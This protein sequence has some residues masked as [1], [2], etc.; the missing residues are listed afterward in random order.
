MSSKPASRKA[1]AS[2]TVMLKDMFQNL[3][4]R[5]GLGDDAIDHGT[6]SVFEAL[7]P[8]FLL[9]ANPL[10][11]IDDRTR[12]LGSSPLLNDDIAAIYMTAT[13]EQAESAAEAATGRITA[14]D[15]SGDVA[16]KSAGP[17]VEIIHNAAPEIAVG[18][19]VTLSVQAADS[20]EIA[21]RSLS[22][23]GKSVSLDSSH[24]AEYAFTASGSYIVVASARNAEGVTGAKTI[25]L[26]V[27]SNAADAPASAPAVQD[28]RAGMARM[29][30]MRNGDIE[31][32]TVGITHNAVGQ[33]VAGQTV[34]FGVVA[35]D[36]TGVT[37]RELIVNG[38]KVTLGADYK[39]AYTFTAPGTYTILAT[40][41]DA[42]KNVGIA[43]LV[44]TVVADSSEMPGVGIGHDAGQN[45]V[46]GQTVNFDLSSD[47]KYPAARYELSV[48]GRAVA[49]DG[50]GRAAY[51]FDRAGV[52]T[53][54]ATVVDTKGNIGRQTMVLSVAAVLDIEAPVVGI[55]HDAPSIIHP[56]QTVN[57]VVSA[58]DN[59][60]VK[61]T[62]FT[63]NGREIA[64]GADGKVAYTFAEPGIYTIVA[65][66]FDPSNNLGMQTITLHVV[67]QDVEAPVVTIGTDAVDAVQIGQTVT[68][69][70]NATDNVG[71]TARILTIN[72]VQ[73]ALDSDYKG[74]FTFTEPGSYIVTA[75]AMDGSANIGVQS[76]TITVAAAPDTEAPTVDIVHNGVGTI[77]AGQTVDFSVVATDNIGVAGMFLLVDGQS[78]ELDADG[79]A[80]YTFAG[81]G[82]YTI[83]AVAFDASNNSN[84][85][86]IVLTV[87]AELD[88]EAP[89]VTIGHNSNGTILVGQTV[90]FTVDAT[91]NVGVVGRAL[92]INGQNVA[93][94]GDFKASFTF[95]EPGTY[96]IIATA[97]DATGNTGTQ[98]LY[99]TVAAPKDTEAPVI[100]IAH[101]GGKDIRPGQTVEF[102]VT[103][104]DNVG[105]TAT[106]FMV[107]GRI[108]ALDAQ[109]KA[110]YTFGEAGTYS[111]LVIASDLAGNHSTETMTI[112]V[113][114]VLDVRPPAVVIAHDV[115]G[116]V[117]VGQKVNFTVTATD[118]VGVTGSSLS[119]NGQAVALDASGKASF[120][121]TSAGTYTIVARAWDAANNVGTQSIVIT[122]EAPADV[123][124]PQVG[125]AHN[126]GTEI[127]AGQ[128]VEITVSAIDNVGVDRM[129]L[130]VNGQAVA[131]D[132][133]GKVLYTFASAGTYTLVA[134]AWDAANNFDSKTLVITV[135]DAQPGDTEKPVVNITHNAGTE[136][137]IGNTVEFTVKA[138]DN[139]GVDRQ[140]FTINGREVAL[141]AQGKARGTFTEA[142]RYEI[143]ATAWDAA[144]NKGEYS[145]VIIV[146]ADTVAPT[147]SVT[148]NGNGNA[149]AYVG[150]TVEFTVSARDNDAVA[151]MTLTVDGQAVALDA[152][153]KGSFTFTAAGTYTVIATAWDA[154]NNTNEQSFSFV[155]TVRDVAAPVVEIKHDAKSETYVGNT[156][157]FTVKATD[158]I[159]VTEQ[160]FTVN[161]R[162]VALVDGK[163]SVTFTEAGI[164]KIVSTATDDSGK[165]GTHSVTI[166]VVVDATAPIVGLSHDGEGGVTE[167]DTVTFTVTATDNDGVKERYLTVNG[168]RVELDSNGRI[169]IV[170]STPGTYTIVAHAEDWAGNDGTAST[171]ITVAERVV[172]DT[173]K[174][175]VTLD[176][177]AGDKVYVGQTIEFTVTAEDNVGVKETILTVNGQRITL[178][179]G[180][181]SF[182]FTA[183]GTYTI[184]ATASDA[185]ENE[186]I[187]TI[188]I[189]VEEQAIIDTEKPTVTLDSN[190]GD[191]VYV[192]QTIEFTVTAEDNVGV[193]ETFLTVNGQR[194]TLEG[195]KASFTFTAAGTYTIVATASDAAENEGTATVVI[196]VEEQAIIDT[197]KPT[198][199]L[200]SNAG[201]KVY[202]GQTIEFTVTAEDNVGVKETFLTVNGQRIILEG[203]KASF[204]F[205]AAGTYTIVATASDAAENEGTAT[206]ILEVSAEADTEKPEVTLDHNAGGKASVGQTVEFIVTAEDNVGVK[207]TYLTVNGQPLVLEG[208]KASFTFTAAG[209]YTFVV[210]ATDEA[211]N[212]GSDTV[213]IVVE[214]KDDN[215]APV[216]SL[217]HD[218]DPELTPGGYANF[219]V[220]ARD[221]VGVER[222]ILTVNGK[223][224]PLSESGEAR[225]QFL[226]YGTYRVEAIAIDYA[227][228]VGRTMEVFLV[229]DPDGPAVYITHYS[230]NPIITGELVYFTV[231]VLSN[232]AV[233]NVQLTMNGQQLALDGNNVGTYTFPAAG[234]YTMQATVMDE[235]GNSSQD[236]FV[237]V[238]EDDTKAP[239]VSISHNA[240]S[241]AYTG[242]TVDFAVKW[243]DYM[244]VTSESFTINGQE[245]AIGEGGVVSY[246]F[247]AAGTYDVVY[248][249]WDD[250]G[251][252]GTQ[253][254]TIKIIDDTVAPS[255]SLSHNGDPRGILTCDIVTFAVTTR[256]NIGVTERWLTIDNVR[257]ELP[258]TGKF[259][260]N[261]AIAGT[262]E[263]AA[264]ALDAAGNLGSKS[265]KITVY[266]GVPDV[267][268]PVVN[269]VHN[270]RSS[271]YIGNT[272][273]FTVRATDN[274]DHPSELMKAISVNGELIPIDGSGKANFTF[275][276]AGT[277]EVIGYALDRSG[278]LGA[279]T[280]SVTVVEDTEKPSLSITHNG[281]DNILPGDKVTFTVSADDNDAVAGRSLTIND[282]VVV[283]LGNSGKGSHI[284]TEPGTYTLVAT[285]WDAAGNT[286]TTSI[287]VTVAEVDTTPP[288]SK[289]SHN[290]RSTI[291][292]GNTVTFTV[293]GTD[294][295]GV[296]GQTLTLDGEPVEL[297]DNGKASITF[298]AAGT[299]EF[300]ATVVDAAGNEG[301]ASITVTVVEDVTAPTV[302]ITHNGNSNIRP[303]DSVAFTVTASDND[304]VTGKKLTV[305]GEE[306]EVDEKGKWNYTFLE[307]GS[308]EVVATAW[309]AAGNEGS[310]S[311]T[312]TVT[313]EDTISPTTSVSRTTGTLYVGQEVEFTIKATDNV[314]VVEQYLTIDDNRVEVD[315]DGKAVYVFTETGTY[316]IV[317][318]AVDAAG[319]EGTKSITVKVIIDTIA[320]TVSLTH[321]AGSGDITIGKTV[322]FTVKSSDNVGIQKQFLTV[323]GE[324]VILNADGM[325]SFTFTAAGTYTI[326][327]SA[328]DAMGN[329]GVKSVTITVIEDTVAPTVKIAH[330]GGSTIF[331]GNTVQF[332]VSATDKAGVEGMTLSIN[333]EAVALDGN[334]VGS[335]TFA[336]AGSYKVVATAVDPSGNVGTN[337]VT[338]TVKA[339]TTKPTVTISHDGGAYVAAGDT[340]EFTVTAKDNSG[341]IKEQTFSI[342]GE[343]VALDAEG[344]FVYTFAS[345][346]KYTFVATAA[347]HAGNKGSKTLVLDVVVRDVT[348]PTVS[349]SHNG[350]AT[351]YAGNKVDIL[352]AA[353]DDVAVTS[354]I[355]T[356][357]GKKVS[358]GGTG[359]ATYTF[360]T[361]GTYEL[362]ATVAD[363]ADNQAVATLSLVVV[364][365][366]VP[367]VID[368]IHNGGDA[369]KAGDKVVFTV[370]GTDDNGI[371]KRTLTVNGNTVT[372]NASTGKATYTFTETGTYEVIAKVIDNAGLES[373]KLMIIVVE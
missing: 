25:T 300:V 132:A 44:I 329:E 115:S 355:L 233:T 63:V 160:T 337:E 46:A 20:A 265:I 69:T 2:T 257:F 313:I 123:E 282:D 55:T 96:T 5:M 105:V 356:I 280:I 267:T 255:V 141:D 18:D 297:D 322:D 108:V 203:G 175:T 145:V 211:G 325:G 89:T 286:A 276:E 363:A 47:G 32:P 24:S 207:E 318:T 209:T 326:V 190:A 361:A 165:V 270:G 120:V 53:I 263:I 227:G 341:A 195:G 56:G 191:K 3:K 156:V 346:G 73:I 319:N 302:K 290:G 234:T 278:N 111:I 110:N 213:T 241:K 136:V 194:I 140:T 187:A 59:I 277:Y 342:N 372:V 321:N 23:N 122:V 68:F 113:K 205:T 52:Y 168:E 362:V 94:D 49:V 93:L 67:A 327:A 373:I 27:A 210:T 335:Y 256:D 317:A 51:T 354:R 283:T 189:T 169:S 162:D 90:D 174:P 154:A 74:Q 232:N 293:K 222:I 158:D 21:T 323:N 109:G 246:T 303:D 212:V 370:I 314:G 208:N 184:V 148:D 39:A 201:D 50:Q 188:V 183:A 215:D 348:P 236:T 338:L 223:E 173:E 259:S 320:P 83:T 349:I 315:A 225:Y 146:I 185:A 95:L 324:T 163:A 240:P 152:D 369:I 334:G 26:V 178:E 307:A 299:Y 247:T 249:A 281:S 164:Y 80:S 266:E 10:G 316:T 143:V 121:F 179:G 54:V 289:L 206:I 42:V 112:E 106:V 262:Y 332:T 204:T 197:E 328:K 275:T 216:V 159:G 62:Q 251:N 117:D 98:T 230:G 254:V 157:N 347:D 295:V 4:E 166:T 7:E 155:V 245:V 9:S 229:R 250:A 288:V 137:Y 196:T 306:I 193:K 16:A 343:A 252:S 182:T 60:A 231:N 294:N 228:N 37:G 353:E 130:T 114:A 138:T 61:S 340:V 149:S 99:L 71:V 358:V 72:G 311:I 359:K 296:T 78:L 144:G 34:E 76:I 97:T 274:A 139:E 192:G 219:K 258:E 244:G 19:T 161:G 180:K 153:G 198:V 41:T 118:D 48:N 218:F 344:K 58:S 88:I 292:V 6:P 57:F 177:N 107:N 22:I 65:T 1:K 33:I 147:V 84:T 28:G 248:T 43:S 87:A 352:V 339:D 310:A 360:A 186:G 220:T 309:D 79:S 170:L 287:T 135:A 235:H 272:V 66:A 12:G 367:P 261:F 253:S 75:T 238:V 279:N 131:L 330:N 64:I 13:A 29:N 133:D 268:P 31:P 172:P 221:N 128:Q 357:N 291:Y 171:V 92:L 129:A 77:R 224:V 199:T 305:N 365:D 285:A 17:V 103:A 134:T 86:T 124:A 242:S 269:V 345:A 336:A 366:E 127:L 167:G 351:I 226:T 30:G 239:L 8:R 38:Q 331:I 81:P 101:D 45:P 264:Y 14:Y 125:I 35:T 116:V 40:A 91:D 271:I 151:G 85:R 142:G 11:D 371:S 82:T 181:A 176:S 308:Y 102:T 119:I 284:F 260:Y 202:V 104:T 150:D 333:G 36:N 298:T 301:V 126:G 304:A 217:T 312:V 200:D 350:G 243:A 273:T 100:T 15:L 70:V 214:A 237:V 368:L 364:Q